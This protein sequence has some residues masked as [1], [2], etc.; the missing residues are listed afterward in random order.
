MTTKAMVKKIPDEAHLASFFEKAAKEI[1]TIPM[2]PAR[3]NFYVRGF[4]ALRRLGEM[5]IQPLERAVEAPSDLEV[6]I[7]ALEESPATPEPQK[8][9]ALD[10][11]RLRGIR[12]RDKLL[13]EEG[14]CITADGVAKILH[15][16][17][18]AVNQRRAAGTLLA[19]NPGG[20]AFQFPVWQFGG[21]GLLPGLTEVLREL[22]GCDPWMKFMFFLGAVP[23]LRGRTPLEVLRGGDMGSV[24]RAAKV[25]GQQGP[26]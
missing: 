22:K 15:I 12:L 1:R 23:A 26:A 5:K 21:E 14:G 20:G 16:S 6:L 18:Q 8:L 9:E 10:G 24:L 13:Q 3:R 17:R 19:V 11:A 25:Y 2:E 7:K 4:R